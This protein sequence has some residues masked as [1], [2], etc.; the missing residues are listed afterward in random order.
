MPIYAFF[1]QNI[2]GGI[3]ETSWAIAL[4]SILSGIGTI[5]VHKTTWSHTYRKHLLWGGWLIWLLSMAVY[6]IMQSILMLYLSQILNALGEAM[7][8][9]VFAAEF[10]EKIESNPAGGWA[11]FEGTVSI[12]SGIAAMIGGFIA[13]YYGFD[14]LLYCVILVATLSFLLI[15]YYSYINETQSNEH[16]KKIPSAP[17]SPEGIHI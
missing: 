1:I 7:C 17:T 14:A 3:L 5:L 13:T 12:S 2:G 11:L 8:E 9:P 4:Y 16:S 6:L 10:S 15:A